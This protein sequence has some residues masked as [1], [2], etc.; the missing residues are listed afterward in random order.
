MT[1]ENA[2]T[3]LWSAVELNMGIIG[4]CIAPLKTLITTFNPRLLVG[5]GLSKPSNT[6][7]DLS[8]TTAVARHKSP[9]RRQSDLELVY[10]EKEDENPS[11]LLEKA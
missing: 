3:A 4:I 1:K 2:A 5:P 7:S 10:L 11:Q 8:G 6:E 9:M